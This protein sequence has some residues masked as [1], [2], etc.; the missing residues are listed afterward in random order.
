MKTKEELGRKH[1]GID[2]PEALQVSEG[3]CEQEKMART[4]CKVVCGAPTTL[5]IKGLIMN[6]SIYTIRAN[7]FFLQGTSENILLRGCVGGT[8]FYT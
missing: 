1:E 4:D 2:R 3:S 7:K 6:L 5:V 8:R